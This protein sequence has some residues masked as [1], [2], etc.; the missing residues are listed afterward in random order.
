MTKEEARDILSWTRDGKCRSCFVKKGEAH[1]QYCGVDEIV[2][3]SD[4][5]WAQMEATY[6][7][8]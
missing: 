2:N 7:K 4:E 3:L 6:G 1:K 5:I 8:I